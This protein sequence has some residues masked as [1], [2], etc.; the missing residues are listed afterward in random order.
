MGQG[1]RVCN[2]PEGRS[3]RA[4]WRQ[5]AEIAVQQI[6][7]ARKAGI[8]VIDTHETDT[9]QGKSPYVNFTVPAPYTESGQLM[10]NHVS[11]IRKARRTR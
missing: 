7:K 2:Q 9:T 6:A 5:S 11:W 10:A 4:G 8:I 1:N 3:N